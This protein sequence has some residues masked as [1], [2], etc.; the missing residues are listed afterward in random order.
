ML[1][2]PGNRWALGVILILALTPSAFA[3]NHH[4]LDHAGIFTPEVR[5][6]AERRLEK[7]HAATKKRVIVEVIAQLDEEEAEVYR[8]LRRDRDRVRYFHELA[9]TWAETVDLNG[10][11]VLLCREPAGH[12]VAVWPPENDAFLPRDDQRRLDQIFANVPSRRPDHDAALLELVR[13]LENTLTAN[14]R[15]QS[16]ADVR[17]GFR[18]T[19]TLG[20]IGVL[21]GVWTLAGILRTRLTGQQGEG[22]AA[23]PGASASIL[24]G[25]AAGH[26]CYQMIFGKADPFEAPAI[27]TPADNA[28]VVATPQ[29]VD[30]LIPPMES[31]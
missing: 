12:A 21:M 2:I 6:E 16:S 18:W 29:P 30:D 3:E 14:A 22:V 24:S 19:W 27:P 10:V 9:T 28:A 23:P 8:E 1:P 26:G 11:Y 31:A 7:L 4:V 5:D 17:D 20:G 15:T 13:Q 25:P